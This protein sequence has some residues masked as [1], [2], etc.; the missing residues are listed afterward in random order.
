[1]VHRQ[2]VTR[3]RRPNTKGVEERNPP[4]DHPRSRSHRPKMTAEMAEMATRDDETKAATE[5]VVAKNV[6][7]R[8]VEGVGAVVVI[9]PPRRPTTVRETAEAR[10][11]GVHETNSIDWIGSTS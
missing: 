10:Q 7:H 11:D 5:T 6:A 3:T 1:M 2:R 9:P 8:E 4:R